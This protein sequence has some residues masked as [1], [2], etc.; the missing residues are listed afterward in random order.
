[1]SVCACMWFCDGVGMYLFLLVCACVFACV[2]VCVCVCACMCVC[3]YEC[4]LKSRTDTLEQNAD[5]EE[6]DFPETKFRN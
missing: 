6:A 2:Y 3:V 4:I 5:F 1:M